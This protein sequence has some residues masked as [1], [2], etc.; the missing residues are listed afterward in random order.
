CCVEWRWQVQ[1]PYLEKVLANALELEGEWDYVVM[2]DPQPAAMLD[3]ARS[4]GVAHESTKWIWRCH[5]DP[6]DANP[7]VWLFVQ[8]FV[9]QY[10]ASVWTMP[11]FVPASMPR[12][13][14]VFAP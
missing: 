1:R 3:Y 7:V 12:D 10:D 6:P 13:K 4:K 9:E 11:E 5:I 2:H 14:T 8:G